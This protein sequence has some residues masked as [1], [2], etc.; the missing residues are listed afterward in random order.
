[1]RAIRSGPAFQ[2]AAR[3]YTAAYKVVLRRNGFMV[4]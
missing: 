3:E 1:M 2:A 4:K